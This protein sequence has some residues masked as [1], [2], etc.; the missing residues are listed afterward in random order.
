MAEG[1]V[2]VNYRDSIEAMGMPKGKKKILL[3]SMTLFAQR[4]FK[5]TSTAQI[6]EES[7]M[8]QASIFKYFPTKD[9]ILVYIMTSLAELL[10]GDFATQVREF[11]SLEDAVEFIVRDRYELVSQ[12]REL[13]KILV[14]EVAI[15]D[16]VRGIMV[17]TFK[18]MVGQLI[19]QIM[20]LGRQDKNFNRDLAEGDVFRIFLSQLGALVVQYFVLEIPGDEERDLH[21][22]AGNIVKLLRV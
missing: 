17:G 22:V 18:D 9:D 12:N 2:L 11:D 15:N 4:G 3:A 7:G 20:E 13:V 16:H 1:N 19:P 8:S 10:V 6:A 5:G 21:M 14:Q